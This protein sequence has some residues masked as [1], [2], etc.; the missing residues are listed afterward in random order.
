M[1][2]LF[3]TG[4]LISFVPGVGMKP[5]S[6]RDE[7]LVLIRTLTLLENKEVG[8]KPLSERDENFAANSITLKIP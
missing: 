3:L 2:T 5:L 6:E 7:N 1:R 8:M 4:F